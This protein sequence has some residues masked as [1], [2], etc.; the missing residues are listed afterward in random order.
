M[1]GELI[2]AASYTIAKLRDEINKL[3]PKI[4]CEGCGSDRMSAILAVVKGKVACCPD[5]TT[6]TVDERNEIREAMRKETDETERHTMAQQHGHG[7]DD[8]DST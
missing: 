1:N 5:C 3:K 4:T 2:G 8:S 7:C 6:L